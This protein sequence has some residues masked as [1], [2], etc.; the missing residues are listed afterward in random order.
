MY[1]LN[2]N[3]IINNCLKIILIVLSIVLLINEWVVFLSKSQTLVFAWIGCVLGIGTLI[4]LTM[5]W[6]VKLKRELMIAGDY[7]TLKD[8]FIN[9]RGNIIKDSL[10]IVNWIILLPFIALQTAN[11]DVNT[12][13]VIFKY[14]G[15]FCSIAWIIWS[16]INTFK[17]N[18]L[19]N[20]FY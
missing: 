18:D 10:L 9:R 19:D 17:K 5:F 13:V 11:F 14:I 3:R 7:F 4:S 20:L 6:I 15:A 1:N 8:A 16:I 12:I 2:L